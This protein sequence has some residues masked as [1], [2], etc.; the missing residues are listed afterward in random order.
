MQTHTHRHTQRNTQIKN[1]L[2][3]INFIAYPIQHVGSYFPNYGFSL[4]PLH[5]EQES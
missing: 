4:C 2:Y 5:W 1:L 3:F